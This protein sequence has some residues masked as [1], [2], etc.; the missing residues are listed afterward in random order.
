[1]NRKEF[2]RNATVGVATVGI[3]SALSAQEH[4]HNMPATKSNKKYSKALMSAI[5]C[6]L[7]AEICLSHCIEEMGKGDKTLLGCATSTRETIAICDSF[8]QIAS[9]DSKFTK[10]TAGL[11]AEICKNCAAECKKHAEHHAICKECMDSCLSCA[12]EMAALS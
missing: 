1:M 6:K 8:I 12:K 9:Q 10:K 7:A 4:K 3:V 2:I 5:H 11:C